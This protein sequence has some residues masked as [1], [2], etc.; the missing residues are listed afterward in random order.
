MYHF[1]FSNI[2]CNIIVTDLYRQVLKCSYVRKKYAVLY[3]IPKRLFVYLVSANSLDWLTA[4]TLCMINEKLFGIEYL[5]ENEMTR[6]LCAFV[7]SAHRC[8]SSLFQLT[9]Q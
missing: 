8:V 7:M 1:H 9:Q 5:L 2:F 6:I 3:V 4:K